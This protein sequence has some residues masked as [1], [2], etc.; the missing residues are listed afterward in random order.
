[1]FR[2]L[3]GIVLLFRLDPWSWPG[4]TASLALVR[5]EAL[6]YFNANVFAS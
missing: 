2:A 6:R 3:V 1:M 4:M 5:S